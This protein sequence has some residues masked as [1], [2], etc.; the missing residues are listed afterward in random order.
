MKSER[1]PPPKACALN[2][3]GRVSKYVQKFYVSKWRLSD[4]CN[5]RKFDAGRGRKLDAG[6]GPLLLPGQLN[7]NTSHMS[8]VYVRN[9]KEYKNIRIVEVRCRARAAPQSCPCNCKNDAQGE[10]TA[11]KLVRHGPPAV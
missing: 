2:R 6:R 4:D 3:C 7:P 8:H 5:P 10:Q 9:Q 11:S 1:T